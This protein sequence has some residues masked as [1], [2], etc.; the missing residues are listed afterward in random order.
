[1]GFFAAAEVTQRAIAPTASD[2]IFANFFIN[3]C[4][5]K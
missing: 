2:N 3:Q 1:M 5:V 4:K